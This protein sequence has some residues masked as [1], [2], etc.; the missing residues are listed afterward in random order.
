[1]KEASWTDREW[2]GRHAVTFNS[3][4]NSICLSLACPEGAFDS[5]GWQDAP[6]T[7]GLTQMLIRC[8]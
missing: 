3:M 4:V 7:V 6:L 1:V 5:E 8:G 2:T